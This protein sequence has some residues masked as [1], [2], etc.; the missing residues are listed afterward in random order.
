MQIL[1]LQDEMSSYKHTSPLGVHMGTKPKMGNGTGEKKKKKNSSSQLDESLLV[2]LQP[3]LLALHTSCLH[4][5][6]SLYGNTQN[7]DMD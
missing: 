3:H 4:C 2:V 6:C 5:G 7:P 1:S